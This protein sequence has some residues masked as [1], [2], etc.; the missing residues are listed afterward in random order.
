MPCNGKNRLVITDGATVSKPICGIK[1]DFTST[2]NEL[3][4][5]VLAGETE[6]EVIQINR[7]NMG[8]I[9]LAKILSFEQFKNLNKNAF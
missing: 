8:I 7:K 1:P 3:Y 6:P 2:T 9:K 4:F 5:M